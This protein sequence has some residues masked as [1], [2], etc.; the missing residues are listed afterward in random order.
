MGMALR[1][2]PA[3]SLPALDLE[4]ARALAEAVRAFAAEHLV[5]GVHDVGDGGLGLALAELAVT[6]GHRGCGSTRLDDHVALFGEAPDRVVVCVEPS[7]TADVMARTAEGGLVATVLGR[8]GGERIVLGSMA[9]V[10]VAD[11][12]E[13]WRTRLPRAFGAATAH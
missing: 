11:A 3:A 12:T 7:R 6:S 10:S 9:N 13:T 4:R 2:P 8:A 5:A 1:A